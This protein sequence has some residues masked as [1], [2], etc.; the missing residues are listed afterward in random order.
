MEAKVHWLDQEQQ[1]E[2]VRM[3]AGT[4][5]RQMR[6]KIQPSRSRCS[7]QPEILGAQPHSAR[8]CIELLA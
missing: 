2:E 4:K 6:S 1:M 8:L 7:Q 5:R 3:P